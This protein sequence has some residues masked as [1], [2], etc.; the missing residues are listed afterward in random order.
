VQSTQK[1]G[2]RDKPYRCAGGGEQKKATESPDQVKKNSPLKDVS[3]PLRCAGE[4]KKSKIL[5]RRMQ[6]STD[7]TQQETETRSEEKTKRSQMNW[8]DT[9]EAYTKTSN[10]ISGP[11]AATKVREVA[12]KNMGKRSA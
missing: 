12:K 5:G 4:K 9:H 10:G 7:S 6:A 8:W 2:N 3:L 11:G 1:G